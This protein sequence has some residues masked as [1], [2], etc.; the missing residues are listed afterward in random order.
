MFFDMDNL[1]TK[2]SSR[3]DVLVARL[4]IS[5]GFSIKCCNCENVLTMNL[6]HQIT[7]TKWLFVKFY[8]F[9]HVGIYG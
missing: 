5:T 7:L 6:G 4:A 8:L 9:Q 3:D 1:A 2:P